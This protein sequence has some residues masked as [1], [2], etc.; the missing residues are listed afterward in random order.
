M[1]SPTQNCWKP[2][3]AGHP[4]RDVFVALFIKGVLLLAIYFLFF[5]PAH[6]H[7]A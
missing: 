5:G 7:P 2:A 6:R 3:A 1:K 4:G